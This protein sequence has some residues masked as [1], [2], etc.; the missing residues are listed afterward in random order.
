[1][2]FTEILYGSDL[3]ASELELRNVVLRIP[4]GLSLYEEN[5]DGER[6]SRHFGILEDG[7][8]LACA[9]LE[10]DGGGPAHSSALGA[11]RRTRF[12]TASIK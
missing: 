10:A 11:I 3:Y 6:D 2:K 7:S 12:D 4:L 9:V 1:M 8:L 5:L